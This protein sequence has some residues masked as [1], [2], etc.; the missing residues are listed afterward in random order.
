MT[1]AELR[2]YGDGN[3]R[4]MYVWQQLLAW[5]AANIMNM[6]SKKTIQP[7]RLLGRSP[8][9]SESDMKAYIDKKRKKGDHDGA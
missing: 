3:G 9:L 4:Q 6:W 8:F 1:M 5:H 2:L 7:S